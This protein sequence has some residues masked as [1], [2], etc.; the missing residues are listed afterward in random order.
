MASSTRPTPDHED[1][2][3]QGTVQRFPF[4]FSGVPGLACRPFMVN[5][6]TAWAAVSDS[7]VEARFGRWHVT[8]PLD[9]VAEVCVTGPYRWPFV[10]GSARLSFSDHGLTFATNDR[11]GVC[12]RF[13]Q[14]I[15]PVYPVP[16][17]HHPGLTVTVADIEGFADLVRARVGLPH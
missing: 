6:A 5:P 4:A 17:W 16:R 11:A 13:R 10:A 15:P 14:P 3:D 7:D 1:A 9:N 2:A 12:L 8:T